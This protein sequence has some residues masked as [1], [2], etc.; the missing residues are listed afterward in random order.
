MSIFS[1]YT[2]CTGPS[3]P[4][5]R[6]GPAR[7]CRASPACWWGGPGTGKKACRGPGLRASGLMANYIIKRASV[8]LPV[9]E[10]RPV[11]H[12]WQKKTAP[13]ACTPRPHLL[14]APNPGHVG[15]PSRRLR[16]RAGFRH[17]QRA[18]RRPLRVVRGVVR[19]GHVPV[20]P[21]PRQRRKNDPASVRAR[22]HTQG[23]SKLK[24]FA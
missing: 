17:Q 15:V 6:A 19:P 14:R 13:L 23:R 3:Q 2:L 18:P 9:G 8:T 1:P 7:P 10:T 22:A 24:G 11:C 16:H 5:H 4:A 21:A 20:G 12:I